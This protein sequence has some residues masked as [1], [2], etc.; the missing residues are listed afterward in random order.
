[1]LNDTDENKEQVKTAIKNTTQEDKLLYGIN[2]Y[3]KMEYI[4]LK[5]TFVYIYLLQ[6]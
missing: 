4:R 5:I 2:F 1:M 3:V 6:L